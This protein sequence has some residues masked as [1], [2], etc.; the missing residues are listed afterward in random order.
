MNFHQ[1]LEATQAAVHEKAHGAVVAAHDRRHLSDVE[2]GDDAQEDGVG[3][4]AREPPHESER[5][6]EIVDQPV[7]PIVGRGVGRFRLKDVAAAT[8]SALLVHESATTDREQPPL[9]INFVAFESAEVP[10][11]VQPCLLG[12]IFRAIAEST[13]E[14]AKQRRIVSAPQ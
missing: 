14:I 2:V 8:A 13:T 5:A 6:I 3:L 11:G 12:E 1:P 10:S 9:E 7:R 4:V